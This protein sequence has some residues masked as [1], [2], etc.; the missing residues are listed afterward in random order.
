MANEI[1][2]WVTK[3]I[4][5]PATIL[6]KAAEVSKLSRFFIIFYFFLVYPFL[7]S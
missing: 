4:G 1:A 3:K 7:V 5:P 2:G 6:E